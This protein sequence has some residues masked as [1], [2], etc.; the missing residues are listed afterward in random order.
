M[1]EKTGRLRVELIH[2]PE[3]TPSSGPTGISVR[4]VAAVYGLDAGEI[5]SLAI[6]RQDTPPD[7]TK[8]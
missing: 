5:F 6:K 4:A 2:R 1:L 3:K 8:S 7:V